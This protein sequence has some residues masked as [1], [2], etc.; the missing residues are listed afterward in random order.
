MPSGDQ[1]DLHPPLHPPGTVAQS[2]VETVPSYRWIWIALAVAFL[3]SL[4]VVLVLPQLV[5]APTGVTE[6]TVVVESSALVKPNAEARADAEQTLQQFLQLQARLELGNAPV[7]GEPVWSGAIKL[8]VS[9]DRMFGERRFADA[10]S[11][12]ADA[13]HRLEQLDGEQEQIFTSALEAGLSALE[14][15]DSETAQK[16]LELALAVKPGHELATRGLARAQVRSDVLQRMT[17]GEVAE[18]NGDLEA[19]GVDYGDALQLDNDYAPARSSLERVSTRLTDI[20]FRA[21]MSRMLTAMDKGQLNE[22]GKALEDAALLKPDDGVVHDARQR[23]T[24]ARQHSSLAVLRRNAAAKVRDEDWQGAAAVYKKALKIDANAGFARDGLARAEARIKLHQQFDHYLNDPQRLY[25]AGPLE[26]AQTLLSTAG[27]APDSEPRLA[28]KINRLE[29]QVAVVR[30]PV[31]VQLLS[32]DQTDIVIYRVARL[33]HFI[34]HQLELR[35]GTYTVVGSR[36]GYR[37]VR[38]VFSVLPGQAPPSVD[39][40]CEEPV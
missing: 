7:W 32:D 16:Q 19:A 29:Q 2:S 36:P 35:P 28:N 6:E 11:T 4:L 10:A 18:R 12:Y 9:G 17:D 15:N 31:Q 21:A 1:P 37:D 38:K 5:S 26:N 34:R 24:Q 23:L 30:V 25:S 20:N 3:L 8:A 40:R 14:A 13:L 39:I 33:G 22:A 27:A